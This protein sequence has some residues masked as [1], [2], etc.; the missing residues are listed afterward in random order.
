MNEKKELKDKFSMGT[1]SLILGI[2]SIVCLMFW[3]IS[4]PTGILAIILGKKSINKANSNI[5]KAGLILGIIG[6]ALFVFIYF[7]FLSVMLL[8]TSI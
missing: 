1:V 2:I 7:S 5:G 6:L 4:L 8:M 3:Y